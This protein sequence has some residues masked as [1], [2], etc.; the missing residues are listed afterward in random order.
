MPRSLRARLTAGLV[1]L[2]ALAC[3]CVGI[4]TVLALQGFLVSRLDQQLVTAGG[5]FAASLEH[6]ARPDA[7]NVPDTRGQADGT[8]GA[9][10]L[11]GRVT[12]AAV[13]HGAADLTVPLTTRD[14]RTLLAVLPDGRPRTIHLSATGAYRVAAW[15]GDDRDILLTG[16]PL[17]PVEETVHRLEAVESVVF[18]AVL[19]TA[20]VAGALWV[21]R[22]LR[23]LD[24]LDRTARDVT[25]LPLAAGQVAMPPPLPADR[26]DTEVGRLTHSF[27]Q[28]LGHVGDALD[29]RHRGEERLRTFAADAGHE[30]RTPVA[31]IRAHA[32]LA[33]RQAAPLPGDVRHALERIEV[34]SRRMSVL[35]DELLLLAR[36]DAGRELRREPVD[37]TR[38]VLDATEDAAARH[39]GHR[40]ELDLPEEPV[41]VT[42]DPERL[43]QAVT[44]LLSNAGR[45]TPEG[46]RVDIALSAGPRWTRLSVTDDG[47]GIPADLR[48]RVFGRFT[49]GDT[50]RA[51][52]TGSTGLGLAIVD[53]VARAH[54][55]RAEVQSRPGRTCFTLVLPS[56]RDGQPVEPP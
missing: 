27:N 9:R 56:A 49:R 17:H 31:T 34:Q 11:D 29:R 16:L 25:A 52:A 48:A 38:I 10:T 14:R 44:N 53:A 22:S 8:F 28:L 5:R 47:P 23:P 50:S 3:T 43:Q 33:L 40:W 55:G 36:L 13:V 46:T 26:P 12:V 30:L 32:E 21:R 37:L 41:E 2:L 7:D 18:A 6:E 24:E 1:C 51:R 42:G 19:V 35:V 4:V 54:S 39:P 15:R 20:G 45:H